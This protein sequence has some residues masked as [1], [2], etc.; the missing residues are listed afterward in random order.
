ML[1]LVEVEDE[2]LT[3]VVATVV[4]PVVFEDVLTVELSVV[5]VVDPPIV[6][7][8]LELVCEAELLPVVDKVVVRL[9]VVELALVTLFDV[10]RVVVVIWPVVV[11][12]EVL[13][14][15]LSVLLEDNVDD[16][17]VVPT[18]VVVELLVVCEMP[19]SVTVLVIAVLLVP[20]WEVALPRSDVC[21]V[22]E[23]VETELDGDV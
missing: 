22:D 6:V 4:V 16:K 8:L 20:D 13:V 19:P 17:V 23:S 15:W 11:C 18:V 7:P 2:E 14:S 9:D 12:D 21:V 1:V 5:E 3:V 10:D